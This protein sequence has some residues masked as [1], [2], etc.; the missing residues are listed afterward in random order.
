MSGPVTWTIDEGMRDELHVE[1]L[2][3]E[4]RRDRLRRLVRAADEI[5]ERESATAVVVDGAM[6][7]DEVEA[8]LAARGVPAKAFWQH[9][10]GGDKAP[11]LRSDLDLLILQVRA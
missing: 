5:L 7:V 8:V 11:L 10:L 3:E 6:S 1:A 4:L 2:A 9:A